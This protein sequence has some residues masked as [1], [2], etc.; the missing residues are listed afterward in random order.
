[1]LAEGGPRVAK[2]KPENYIVRAW[3]YEYGQRR[4]PTWEEP[5]HRADCGSLYE[6]FDLANGLRKEAWV[7]VTRNFGGKVGEKMIAHY[8]PWAVAKQE[9]HRG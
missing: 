3:T 8:P 7:R 5:N 6:A 1:M 2:S 4:A 9:E